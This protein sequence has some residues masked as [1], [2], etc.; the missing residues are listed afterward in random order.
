M[1]Q[2]NRSPLLSSSNPG[3]Q[4]G[5]RFRFLFSSHPG[6]YF[7]AASLGWQ[8]GLKGGRSQGVVRKCLVHGEGLRDEGFKGRMLGSRRG[9]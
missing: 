1:E 5:D 4:Q 2:C 7:K 6:N 9:V 8:E 3:L